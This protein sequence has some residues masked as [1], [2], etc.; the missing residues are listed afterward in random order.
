MGIVD[1]EMAESFDIIRLLRNACAH[2]VR[3]TTFET[4][5]VKNVFALLFTKPD[6][7]EGY[8]SQQQRMTLGLVMVFYMERMLGKS[9][10]QAH[11]VV[12]GIVQKMW[13]SVEEHHKQAT[14]PETQ[15]EQ[16]EPTDHQNQKG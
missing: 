1:D 5:A 10:E 6:Q 16:S 12:E 9:P 13:Q 2:S 7:L 3:E 4:P 15:S 8:D 11:A 14:S